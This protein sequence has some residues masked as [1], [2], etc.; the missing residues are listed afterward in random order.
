MAPSSVFSLAAAG[1]LLVADGDWDGDVVGDGLGEA[2]VVVELGDG[3][4]G[5]SSSD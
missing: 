4:A 5:G 3:V 2:P 1:M